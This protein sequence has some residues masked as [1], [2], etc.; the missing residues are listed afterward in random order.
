MSEN[1]EANTS[2]SPTATNASRTLSPNLYHDSSLLL[3][4]SSSRRM[5]PVKSSLFSLKT[6]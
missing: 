2:T 1:G 5:T 4:T 6:F 3:T